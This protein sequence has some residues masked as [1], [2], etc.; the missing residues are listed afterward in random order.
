MIKSWQALEEFAYELIKEDNPVQPKGSG[1]AKKEEDVV[2]DHIIVQC[3]YTDDKNMSILSKDLSRL[4]EACNLQSKFP[5]FIT[6]NGTNTILSIPIKDNNEEII[7]QIITLISINLRLDKIN[8][9]ILC[10]NSVPMLERFQKQLTKTISKARELHEG[11]KSRAEKIVKKL[12]SKYDDLTMY[13]LFDE[14]KQCH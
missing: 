8:D 14:D 13:N 10:I 3:K 12:S 5:L 9:L 6:S 7:K 2:S 11:F 1:S 4:L